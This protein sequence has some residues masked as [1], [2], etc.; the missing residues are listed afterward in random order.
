MKNYTIEECVKKSGIPYTVKN[1]RI[2]LLDDKSREYDELF[3]QLTT[4]E[5]KE[6]LEKMG[7]EF[8]F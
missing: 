4:E 5:K 3:Q 2:H 8:N 6:A 1:N 7:F